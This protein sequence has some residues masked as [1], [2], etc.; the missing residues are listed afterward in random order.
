[1][2]I[3][4]VCP[5]CSKE[6]NVSDDRAGTKFR[7]KVCKAVVP[8]VELEES[9]LIQGRKQ[10]VV[11]EQKK[12]AKKSKQFKQN[13]SQIVMI[14]VGMGVLMAIGIAAEMV[15]EFRETLG[16]ILLVGGIVCCVIA[17][18]VVWMTEEELL[19]VLI[20]R[21]VPLAIFATALTRLEETW[22]WLL[23]A[24]A[25]GVAIISGAGLLGRF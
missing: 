7:C 8:V 5:D 1:M 23:L 3:L 20:I 19:L 13:I 22:P 11:N 16:Q 14:L 6:Y 18:A 9:P 15:P 25:G 24:L 17:W 21:F 10:K 2:S 4:A 12:A